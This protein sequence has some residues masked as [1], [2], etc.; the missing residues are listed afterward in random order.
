MKQTARILAAVA[1]F[2]VL[3]MVAQAALALDRGAVPPEPV[4]HG[5]GLSIG[6][7][8]MAG[9]FTPGVAE[10]QDRRVSNPREQDLL[11]R[12]LD[13]KGLKEDDVGG[14][15][16]AVSAGDLH[17]GCDIAIASNGD[18]YVALET[19]DIVGEDGAE[20]WMFR[21]LDGGD[22]W[23]DWGRFHPTE[24]YG[25]LSRPRLH[26]AEGSV[27]RCYLAYEEWEPSIDGR[28]LVAYSDLSAASGS[29][30]VVSALAVP[31][32]SFGEPSIT[33]DSSSYDS[34]YLYLTCS[35]GDANGRDIWFTRSTDQ[36]TS[37]ETPYMIAELALSDRDYRSP[38]VSYGYGGYVHVAYHFEQDEDT[39]DA[40]IRYR[41]ASNYAGDGIGSWAPTLYLTSNANDSWEWFP[42]IEA[43]KT[44]GDVMIVSSNYSSAGSPAA[45]IQLLSTDQGATFTNHG[46]IAGGLIHPEDLDRVPTTG[47]WVLGGGADYPWGPGIQYASAAA[48][49]S[50]STKN[51]FVDDK[52]ATGT[53]W[54]ATTTL[55]PA[56]D[57]RVGAAWVDLRAESTDPN[58]LNFDA[59]WRN[60][61][62]YPNL[63]DGFPV[64][65][66]HGPVS[67]PALVDLNGDGADDIVY[68]DDQ[69]RIW[70]WN[71]NGTSLPGFP[72]DTGH[73]LSDGPVAVGAL[74]PGGRL[75]VVAGTA[76]GWVVAY[77]ADG[78]TA[79]GWPVEMADTAPVY[80]SL[81]AL[82]APRVRSVVICCGNALRFR[83]Y[84]GEEIP[85][86]PGWSF[87]AGDINAPAAIGDVDGD[88]LNDVVVGPGSYA[89]CFDPRV[90][91]AKFV[92]GS[93]GA[94]V[95]DQITLGDLDL[96][97]DVE[98]FIPTAGGELHVLQG[99]GSLFSAAFPFVSSTA[100]PLTSAA[101]GQCLSTGEPEIAVAA[102]NWTVHLL[103]G[104]DGTQTPWSP[105]YT[106]GGWYL[107]GMPIIGRVDG[108][109][110]DV[111]IGDRSGQGWA[112]SNF[113]TVVS[114]WPRAFDHPCNLSPAIG[115]VNGDGGSD[116]AF[117][118]TG[119]LIVYE[120][121]QGPT[122]DSRQWPMYGYDPQ[123]TG[124]AN[125]PEDLVTPVGTEE[126][127]GITRL[128]FALPAPN[129]MPGRGTFS[130]AVPVRAAAS[131]E[132]FDLRGRLVRRILR[133]EVAR[134]TRTIDWDCR[135]GQGR[136]LA[137]G[138]YLARLK[139]RG[140]GL[141]EEM[142]RKLMVIR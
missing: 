15:D 80:V 18:I 64:T 103:Y 10:R 87:G 108:I 2:A 113:G 82:G 67:P 38:E 44:T 101:L 26:I 96:D 78:T 100:S 37:Y 93:M 114:G 42:V 141:D 35:S 115:D 32:V 125:C 71:G 130:F 75:F 88:G 66:N 20:I 58:L 104:H 62:G 132:V 139:V 3:A 55:D 6:Q 25:D 91:A 136:E 30:T 72:I 48:P 65:L 68:G 34:F 59:E 92:H 23:Q 69:G 102:R 29:W 109:S 45:P 12:L 13:E 52:S 27:E 17:R 105:V 134:G 21:S 46:T 56:H 50:W 123:R 14:D 19:G 107:L 47:A 77:N 84:R 5:A 138:Q 119:Q 60:D 140:P 73:P 36:G 22:S 127:A 76:D 16:V 135:D 110:S 63:R 129:P 85:E 126:I 128:G 11:L 74:T 39:M 4:N 28:I 49:T 94:D 7:P 40:A 53:I 61:P 31:D 122:D 81:G 57:Y 121:N 86:F 51:E 79:D 90:P 97:G 137:A 117:L 33:S 83:D 54:D 131:L 120:I 9:P 116:I 95:S 106:G 118:T 98:I 133:E 89:Y 8:D 142:V 1:G 111:V 70:A 41:R 99:D 43:S 124:C 112:W 24:T